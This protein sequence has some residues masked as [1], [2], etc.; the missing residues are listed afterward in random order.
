[1]SKK[2]KTAIIGS[3][4][5]ANAA[6]L[7]AME[8]L[9]DEYEV[10]AVTDMRLSAAKETAER[11]NIPAYYDDTD[12]MLQEVKPDV[13]IVATSNAGHQE[14]ALKA[15]RAGAN[16]ICEKPVAL[17]YADAVELFEEAKKNGVHFFPAQT[18]RFKTRRMAA[19]KV[20]DSGALGEI[21]FAEF[22]SLRRRGVPRW[23]FFHM[24]EYNVGGPFCD[25]GVHEIDHMLSCLG[26]PKAVSV[27]G[28]TWTR[29]ANTG[30]ELQTSAEQ[31]GAFGGIHITPREY[32]WHEFNVEDMATGIIRLEGEKTINFKTSWA[33]NLPDRWTRSYAG[34]KA[35]LL[36]GNDFPMSIHGG[37]AGWQ[38]DSYPKVFPE[39]DY[40]EELP[41]P[42]H[43]GL[44]KNVADV[45]RGKAEP[46]VKEEETLNLTCIIEAFYISA[47]TN[48]EVSCGDITGENK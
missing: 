41:F 19:K 43:V 6:H 9:K 10:A 23:G 48:K 44:L 12:K 25:L 1:M 30:E 21:Y 39:D 28:S 22:E 2:F 46:V 35:G 29:I 8:V 40:H 31:G 26:N 18:E 27:S 32:D 37:L 45:L 15:L 47:E 38:S 5:I 3:G 13:V 33:V 17:K 4:L 11:Y 16:V 20:I 36:Y 34:T 42:G 14:A 7:P 24:K